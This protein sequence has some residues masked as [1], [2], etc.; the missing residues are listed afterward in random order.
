MAA[1][2]KRLTS[3]ATVLAVSGAPAVLSACM[4]QC[5]QAA[6]TAMADKQGAPVE[7]AAPASTEAVV[8]GH[9][10]HGSPPAHPAPASTE[11]VVSGHSHHGS[12]PA[13]SAPALADARASAH[14]ARV[15]GAR[16]GGVCHEC[17]SAGV[18][19]VAVASPRV[20]RMDAP[21]FGAAATLT[22]VARDLLTAAVL[23][24]APHRPPESLPDTNRAPLVLRI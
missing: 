16:L 21:A 24:A 2:L 4:A 7:Q 23:S 5:V 14:E 6:M 3:L 9:S 13:H 19:V 8:S 17:C 10:H 11:A 15:S 20:E 18:A 22:P 12:P 1:W